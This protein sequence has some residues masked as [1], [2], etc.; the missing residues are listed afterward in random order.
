M[1]KRR[2]WAAAALAGFCL[3]A[4]MSVHAHETVKVTAGSAAVRTGPGKSHAVLGHVSEGQVYV[5][6]DAS[7][8]WREI[9]YGY[10]KGWVWKGNLVEVNRAKRFVTANHLTVRAGPGSGYADVG[11]ARKGS[12]W[13]M[14]GD[15][16]AW[17]K[18]FFRGKA[19]WMHSDHLTPYHVDPPH[20][21]KSSIGFVQ[22]PASGTGFYASTT[23]E[24]RWGK[25]V[26][27]YGLIRAARTWGLEH[28]WARIGYGDISKASG[29][30]FPPH[31]SHRLGEDVDIRLVSSGS[32]EG[33]M[34]YTSSVYSQSRTRD[35]ITEH[36]NEELNLDL[37]LFND[38]G[39]HGP[40]SYVMPYSGHDNHLHLRIK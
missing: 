2:G 21:P 24:R 6:T 1:A 4:A 30:Y 20:L 40:L 34:Y 31:V 26:L 29:G 28:D 13:A 37:I 36:L 19:A 33:P 7:G 10:A 12:C 27:V 8:E 39:I 18:V 25:P 17:R 15:S 35:W 38:P 22:M 11:T 5:R 23:P 16:G 32:Y 9:W 14:V 3:V